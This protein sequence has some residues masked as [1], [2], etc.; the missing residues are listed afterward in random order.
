MSTLLNGR[1]GDSFRIERIA[2][3]QS[4]RR[5]LLEMGLIPGTAVTV[6]GVG[7]FGGRILRVGDARIA[8]DAGTAGAIT[9]T[10]SCG[11]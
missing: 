7:V 8:V 3:Q 5:R 1:P 6:T 9:V 4:H 10:E 2:G 11:E